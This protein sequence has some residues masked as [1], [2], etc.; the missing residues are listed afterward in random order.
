MTH[1][2]YIWKMNTPTCMP[3]HSYHNRSTH[4]DY[5]TKTQV[6]VNCSLPKV[7]CI[8]VALPSMFDKCSEQGCQNQQCFEHTAS[9]RVQE[10]NSPSDK[11]I[12]ST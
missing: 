6:A 10:E 4:G 9:A 7:C 12:I 8:T 2:E 3:M 1:M 11:M 5:M